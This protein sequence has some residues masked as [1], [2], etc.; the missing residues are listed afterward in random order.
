V[1]GKIDH[2]SQPLDMQDMVEDHSIV[3]QEISW[4]TQNQNTSKTVS[5]TDDTG[6]IITNPN[7]LAFRNEIKKIFNILYT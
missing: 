4:S 5:F 2:L 6:M 3:G 7:P 1:N